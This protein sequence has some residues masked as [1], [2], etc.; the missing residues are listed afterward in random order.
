MDLKVWLLI[1]SIVGHN[2]PDDTYTFNNNGTNLTEESNAIYHDRYVA[3]FPLHPWQSTGNIP[4]FLP[5]WAD[6]NNYSKLKRKIL[7][8]LR[9][10]ANTKFFSVGTLNLDNNTASLSYDG[11]IIYRVETYEGK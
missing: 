3:A 1:C 9:Y 11:L 7:S 4:G 5:Y 6:K 8:N 10:S 2:N